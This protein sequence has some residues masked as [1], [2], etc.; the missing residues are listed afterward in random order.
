[1]IAEYL[2]DISEALKMAQNN[3]F[4]SRII[5]GIE[6]IQE[7]LGGLEPLLGG[8]DRE[9]RLKADLEKLVGEL[10]DNCQKQEEGPSLGNMRQ[11]RDRV[12]LLKALWSK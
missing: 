6:F 1:M 9:K 10:K 8:K 7:G 3:K 11:L 5:K 12:Q 2:K 4:S